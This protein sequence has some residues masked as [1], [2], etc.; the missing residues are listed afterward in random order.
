MKLTA[1]TITCLIFLSSSSCEKQNSQAEIPDPPTIILT[2]GEAQIAA[3]GNLTAFEILGMIQK[4]QPTDPDNPNIMISPLSLNLSM[5]MAWNGASGNTK[6]QIKNSLE[7]HGDSDKDVQSFF[8]KM[9]ETLPEADP[10]TN[11][12]IAN[13]VWYNHTFPIKE[14]F[15]NSNK[16]WFHATISPLDFS[17][18]E[19]LTTINNWCSSKSNGKINKILDNI[20]NEEVMFLINALYFKSPWSEKFDRHNTKPMPFTLPNGSKVSVPMMFNNTKTQF[21]QNNKL[22]SVNI[23]FGNGAFKMTI[24][25]PSEEG[26][27]TD[28]LNNISQPDTWNNITNNLGKQEVDI[29][30]PR[31]KFEYKIELNNILNEIGIKNAFDPMKANFS[32]IAELTGQNNLSISKVLQKTAI[33]I[34]E[35]GGEAA[36][37]T[38]TGFQVTSVGPE[39]EIF[40]ADRPFIFAI[41]E[42]S[43]G[44]IIFSGIVAKP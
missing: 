24:I 35:E 42:Q 36:A 7:F 13:S 26:S 11:I 19:S 16:K 10:L 39:K 32:A 28:V 37:V 25:L 8:N 15:L 43:T 20:S 44:T 38:S 18:K 33:E 6:S 9:I 2:K 34:N 31:F 29:Y 17:K 21:Y 30:L 3:S 41:W 12:T 27:L 1:I 14:S 22:S 23:P 5:A 40:I 4:E